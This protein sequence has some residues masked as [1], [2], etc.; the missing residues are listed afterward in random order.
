MPPARIRFLGT[1]A[2]GGTPGAGRSRR[3][4]SSVLAEDESASVLVDVT[5]DFE[6][7]SQHL[8]RLDAVVLTH[9][10]ADACGGVAS[11]QQW[12][13]R[14]GTS[15]PFFTTTATLDVIRRRFGK[16]GDLELE[17]FEPG[18][19]A[20]IGTWTLSCREVPH[21]AD[22]SRFPTVA[23]R[24]TS[25]GS[26]FVYA[27]DVARL[28]AELRRFS[29]DASVLVIDGATYKRRI[30]SHLRIDEDL[31][32]VCAWPVERILLTQIGR[33]APPHVDLALLVSE[34][35]PR[36][37]PAYDGLEVDL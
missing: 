27:S 30:F 29:R 28:E 21:A 4:E 10:H 23:W 2:S 26:S 18:D 9:G 7:Q 33:S 1:G 12:L 5:R 24:L 15:V 11:L 37:E 35:C 36:A 20:R 25:A 16:A 14:Q 8:S 13:S 22:A 3:R 6:D 31:P 34:L 17:T 32:E 19:R